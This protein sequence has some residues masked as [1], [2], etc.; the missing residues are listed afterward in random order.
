M[1]TGLIASLGK[2]LRCQNSGNAFQLDIEILKAGFAVGIRIGD[3]I[4]VNGICLTV[5]AV[6]GTKI[7]MDAMPQTAELTTLGCW[8]PGQR[9]NLEKALAIGDRLDGH[10][11]TGHIDCRGKVRSLQKDCNAIRIRLEAPAPVMRYIIPQG[12]VALD[13]ISLTVTDVERDNFAVSIIPHTREETAIQGWQVGSQVNIETDIL[14]KYLY[15][16]C[17]QHQV[18]KKN[19][20]LYDLLRKNNFL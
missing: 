13:G 11:V 9:L 3:S 16:F 10:W 4:A 20:D 18:Q 5:T 17:S 6:D 14:G 8:Q 12:S 1:F 2:L 19:E 15:H 7:T